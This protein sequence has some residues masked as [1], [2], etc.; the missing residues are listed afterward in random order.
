[1]V[2]FNPELPIR[3]YLENWSFASEEVVMKEI[4][5]MHGDPPA[6]IWAELV[7]LHP[8]IELYPKERPKSFTQMIHE[9]VNWLPCY[10]DDWDPKS[11]PV[12]GASELG[13]VPPGLVKVMQDWWNNGENISKG[14]IDTLRKV[15]F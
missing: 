12:Y 2:E 1:M 15:K 11:S 8:E 5:S 14:T 9:L 7:D 13:K 3:Y 6:N 4:L 10:D